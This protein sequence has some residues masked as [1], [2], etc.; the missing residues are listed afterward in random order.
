MAGHAFLF[1]LLLLPI[2]SYCAFRMLFKYLDYRV[3]HTWDLILLRFNVKPLGLCWRTGRHR[4]VFAQWANISKTDKTFGEQHGCQ[5]PNRLLNEFPLGLDRLHQIFSADA[6]NRLMALFLYHFRLWGDTLEQ[7]FLGTR[8]L[9]TIDPQNLE[10]ILSTQFN[11]CQETLHLCTNADLMSLDFGYGPRSKIFG[12]L[13][14]D[15]IF[16]QDHREWK[17]SRKLL[18]PQFGKNYYRDLDFFGEHVD[19]LCSQIPK[20]GNSVDLQPLFF[21]FTLDTTTVCC[22]EL[23]SIH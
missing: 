10:A 19:N 20:D 6:N 3:R 7:V 8:A 13:L 15:G 4:T 22:L 12:P 18:S 9:G 11:G 1:T 5:P 23:P 2:L 16:T 21:K 17:H 14:G